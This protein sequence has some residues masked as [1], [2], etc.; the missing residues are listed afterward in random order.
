MDVTVIL[1]NPDLNPDQHQA[2]LQRPPANPRTPRSRRPPGTARR[3]DH[4]GNRPGPSWPLRKP[5]RR[6][7]PGPRHGGHLV[8]SRAS[9]SR[10]PERSG[11]GPGHDAAAPLRLQGTRGREP[12]FRRACPEITRRSTSTSCGSFGPASASCLEQKRPRAWLIFRGGVVAARP[13]ASAGSRDRPADLVGLPPQSRPVSFR[14][15][16]LPKRPRQDYDKGITPEAPPGRPC[17]VPS[18]TAESGNVGELL[19]RRRWRRSRRVGRAIGASSTT[20]CAA[21]SPCA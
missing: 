3:A 4:G 5:S 9:L 2:N 21:W 14:E 6:P 1:Y 12:Q 17:E 15:N 19:R 13:P 8:S 18:M 16:R 7:L 10:R 11:R 20:A